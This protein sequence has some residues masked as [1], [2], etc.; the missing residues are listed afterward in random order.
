MMVKC[1]F[2]GN[3][4]SLGT[5]KLYVKKDGKLLYFDARKCEKNMLK[6]NRKARETRWTSEYRDVKKAALATAAAEKKEVKAE[7][8]KEKKEKVPKE[9]G[10]K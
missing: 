8:V 4:L 9:K 6:L 1:S 3:E 7:K 10:K 2:C 5:G